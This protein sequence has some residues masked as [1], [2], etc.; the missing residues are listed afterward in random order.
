MEDYG[1]LKCM[2]ESEQVKWLT[3]VFVAIDFSV[4]IEDGE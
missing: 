1:A 4:C 3:T 2:W